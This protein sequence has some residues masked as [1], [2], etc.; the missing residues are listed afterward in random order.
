MIEQQKREGG[1]VSKTPSN[2][3]TRCGIKVPALNLEKIKSQQRDYYTKNLPFDAHHRSPSAIQ[4]A[5][6]VDET[7]DF[8]ENDELS[9]QQHQP[10]KKFGEASLVLSPIHAKA[11]EGFVFDEKPKKR[12]MESKSTLPYNDQ[13]VELR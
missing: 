10:L 2:A 13:S 12:K 8:N 9:M 11:E 1:Y 3:N 6:V 4:Y 7:L 5:Q